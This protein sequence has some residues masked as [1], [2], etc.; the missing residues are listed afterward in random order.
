MEEE[1]FSGMY[2]VSQAVRYLKCIIEDINDQ[3][4][5]RLWYGQLQEIDKVFLRNYFIDNFVK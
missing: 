2:P 3:E 4:K 5:E 1:D